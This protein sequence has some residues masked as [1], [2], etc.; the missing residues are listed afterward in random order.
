MILDH[1]PKEI[2]LFFPYFPTV[3]CSLWSCGGGRHLCLFNRQSVS[4]KLENIFL[5]SWGAAAFPQ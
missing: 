3:L 2:S 1:S 5:N 4:M